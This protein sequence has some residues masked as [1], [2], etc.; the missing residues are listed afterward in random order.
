MSPGKTYVYG[1][2][3]KNKNKTIDPH[4]S[5]FDGVLPLSLYK[6]A[7]GK[8]CTYSAKQYFKL[9]IYLVSIHCKL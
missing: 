2:D 6:R 5:I 1:I 4:P 9:K 7:K 8:S 3:M